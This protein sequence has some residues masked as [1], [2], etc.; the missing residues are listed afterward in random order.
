[1]TYVRRTMLVMLTA[2]L[3]TP[4]WTQPG[5]QPPRVR[6]AELSAAPWNV[7][8]GGIS[9]CE[10]SLDETGAVISADLLQDV[11]PYGAQLRDD[12]LSSWTF[13]PAREQGRSVPAHVLVLGF[14]LPP[15]LSLQKPDK[16]LYKTTEAPES[17]PWPTEVV[18]PPYPP[19]VRGSGMVILEADISDEGLVSSA[20]V[21]SNGSAFDSAALDSIRRWTFRPAARGGR[22]VGSR[23]FLVVSFPV[24]TP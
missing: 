10:L 12:I 22:P 20:R 15:T 19:N 13:E 23:A 6:R 3:T 9:V 18:A 21:L 11:P 5:P 7:H 4:A 2:V 24:V 16:P 1:M 17:V 8:S 14:F